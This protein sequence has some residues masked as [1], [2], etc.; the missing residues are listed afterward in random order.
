MPPKKRPAAAQSTTKQSRNKVKRTVPAATTKSTTPPITA[1]RMNTDDD[2]ADNIAAA[3]L[4]KLEES[5]RLLPLPTPSTSGRADHA[6]LSPTVAS[7]P[8]LTRPSTAESPAEETPRPTSATVIEEVSESDDDDV[9]AVL[10]GIL[11][12]ELNTPV[13]IYN[14]VHG[15][16]SAH[17]PQQV[18]TKIW[19]GEYVNLNMLLPEHDN[20]DINDMSAQQRQRFNFEVSSMGKQT[21]SLAKSSQPR[22][23][24]SIEQWTSA[25]AVY[26][27][28][29]T[30]HSQQQAPGLFKHISD[31]TEMARR[32][33]G[34]AWQ[35]YDTTFRNEMKVNQLKFGNSHWNLRFRCLENTLTRTREPSVGPT[36]ST[37]YINLKTQYKRGTC[38]QFK[39]HGHCS[40][41]GC[42][43]IH[44]CA[45]CN[46]IHPTLRCPAHTAST[47]QIGSSIVVRLPNATR[48]ENA[49]PLSH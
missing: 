41:S 19:R 49:G 42:T 38:Y 21:L 12:G 23:I 33:G 43:F 28:V 16:L 36:P 8:L 17:L 15:P 2:F 40:R 29:L 37:P 32:F 31:V 18:R 27:A 6:G 44:A 11:G 7:T 34:L 4:C 5:G 20:E 48:R 9:D 3:V 45:K 30:E 24:K 39:Q 22:S 25:F 1:P 13:P 10:D 46:G 35:R 47:T 14:V 26:S